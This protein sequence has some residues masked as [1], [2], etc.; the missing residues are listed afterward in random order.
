MGHTT[1]RDIKRL[2]DAIAEGHTFEIKT[3]GGV[4]FIKV[5]NPDYKPDNGE[6]PYHV[7]AVCT[8]DD[9]ELSS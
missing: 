2:V 3:M 7:V 5:E 4:T 6:D 1:Q 9:C 8:R